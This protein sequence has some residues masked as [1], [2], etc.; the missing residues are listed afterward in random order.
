[1]SE[2][3]INALHGLVHVNIAKGD[4]AV[5]RAANGANDKANARGVDVVE[6]HVGRGVL[7]GDGIVL[8]PDVA[9]VNVHVV[10]G[11]IK[12]VGV[13]GCHVF[14]GVLFLACASC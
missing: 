11:H 6:L 1:M 4:V 2:L 5:V 10:A 13:E 7:D 8:A 12:A 14:Q 3:H 9:V